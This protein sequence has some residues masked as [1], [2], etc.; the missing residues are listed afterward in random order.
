MQVGFC[1]RL[2]SGSARSPRRFF[3]YNT[4]VLIVYRRRSIINIHIL[5]K[6]TNII[7]Y[8]AFK[9]GVKDVGNSCS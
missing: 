6:V 7:F 8:H 4:R 5:F 1:R 3:K 9:Y 2:I